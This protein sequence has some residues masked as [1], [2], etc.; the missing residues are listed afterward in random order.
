[1]APGLSECDGCRKKINKGDLF[2]LMGKYPGFI[3]KQ[4]FGPLG[5]LDQFLDCYL[6]CDKCFKKRFQER[7]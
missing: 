1:M 3:Q 2:V 5:G 6:L 4:A 7:K